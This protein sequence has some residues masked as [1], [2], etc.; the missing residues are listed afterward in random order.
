MSQ[1]IKV[2]LLVNIIP[3]YYLPVFEHLRDLLGGLQVFV[4]TPMEPNRDWRT[5]WGGLAVTVQNCWTYTTNWRHEQGFSDKIWRHIP[6]DTL[7][8]LIRQ[9]PDVVISMQLGF[10]TLQAA[11]YRKLFPRSRLIVWTGLSEHTEKGLPFW[12]ILQRRALLH[13][14]DAVLINGAS[15]TEYLVGLGVPR[16]EI[17]LQLYCAEIAP[18]LSL[19]LRREQNVARRL[20]YVGQLTVRKGLGPFLRV[21]CKWLSNHPTASCEFWIAGDGPLR[22][23]LEKFLAPSQLRLRFTG[24]VTYEKLPELYAQAGIFV[25]PTL[26]DEW[27]VVVNEALASG[28]PVLGST[29]SQAV[30]ELIKDGFNGWTFRPDNTDEMYSAL[31]K[32]MTV[33]DQQLEE[34]RRAGRER[35]RALTPRYGANCFMAAIDFV[36][37]TRKTGSSRNKWIPNKSEGTENVEASQ[38]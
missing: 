9:R 13:L 19:C 25:F 12:R 35:I 24:S 3:P 29:Y 37:Q 26:A 22:P 1:D 30:E 27:G 20:L 33:Q 15:G 18:H 36:L 23:E 7:P 32:A 2:C 10:R 31:D 16:N 6:Y 38:S 8:I 28:L 21:L 34:M 17:F 14:A 5:E 11:L 4:S